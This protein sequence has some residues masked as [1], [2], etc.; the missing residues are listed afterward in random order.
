[1]IRAVSFSEDEQGNFIIPLE[2]GSTGNR[3]INGMHRTFAAYAK[4]GNNIVVDYILYDSTWL[5][6]LVHVL[7]DYKVYFVGVRIPLSIL[8]EREK[9]RGTSPAGH[10]RSHY[11]IVHAHGVYD[12]EFDTSTLTPEQCAMKIKDFIANNPNPTAF[13]QLQETYKNN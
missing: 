13:K 9:G 12:L 5:P 2:I 10:A 1:M 8:E 4:T 3:V 11:D 6:D 7:K